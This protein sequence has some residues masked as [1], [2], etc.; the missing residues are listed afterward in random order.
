MLRRCLFLRTGYDL[1]SA[2][3]TDTIMKARLRSLKLHWTPDR[4]RRRPLYWAIRSQVRL[5]EF[6]DALLG[7]EQLSGLGRARDAYFLRGFLERHRGRHGGAARFY[8]RAVAD[9]YG[10]LAI[11]RDLAEC[12]LHLD[13]LDKALEHVEIARSKQADNRFV[14]DLQVKILCRERKEG[15]ARELLPLLDEVDDQS[16]AVHR[17]SRVA[18]EFSRYD[19]A[20]SSAK[21]A[22]Q[23]AERPAFEVLANLALCEVMTNRLDDAEVTLARLRQLYRNLRKD[24]QTAIRVN[25]LLAHRDYET[26]LET[27]AS[28]ENRE[29]PQHLWLERQALAGILDH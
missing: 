14:V 10:G 8:E 16:F 2:S 18:Y 27:C 5:G 13:Q 20:Y 24:V 17:R 6:E 11:H 29:R 1:L 19:E 7:I 26:A 21:R 25:L 3:I 22:A 15:E 4:Q 23:S 12:Y 9:G 28:F